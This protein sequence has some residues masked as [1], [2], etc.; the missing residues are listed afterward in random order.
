MMWRLLNFFGIAD[1]FADLSFAL[2]ARYWPKR[3][4]VHCLHKYWTVRPTRWW[5]CD[6]ANCQRHRIYGYPDDREV[7]FE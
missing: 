4:C 7:M 5:F 3:L 2:R 1:W 6:H